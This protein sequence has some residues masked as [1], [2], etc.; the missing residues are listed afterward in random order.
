MDPRDAELTRD[1]GLAE[2]G[3]VPK[4]QDSPLALV[5]RAE[6]GSE[7]E[8]VIARVERVLDE[9][10]PAELAVRAVRGGE[11]DHGPRPVDRDRL[12]GL[13]LPDTCVPGELRQRGRSRQF[14]REARAVRSQAP[15]QLRQ[16]ARDP[17]RRRPVAQVPLDLAGDRG[18]GKA[19]KLASAPGVEAVDRLDQPD[20]AHLHEI[21]HTLAAVRI[22]PRKCAD[23]RQVELDQPLPRGRVA[24]LAVRL[25]ESPRLP[26]IASVHG[27]C[28][29]RS[30]TEW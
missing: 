30:S 2:T 13:A 17:H 28:P 6:P 26:V 19:R 20:A 11:R 15:V 1:L 14:R 12:G 27:T 5:E 8:P 24:R 23:E 18:H 25:E 21:L 10:R 22:A 16:A 7:E 29:P 4:M 3:E 9:D